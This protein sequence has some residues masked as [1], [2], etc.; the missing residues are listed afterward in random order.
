MSRKNIIELIK[1]RITPMDSEKDEI[2]I[3]RTFHRDDYKGLD[4]IITI[5]KNYPKLKKLWSSFEDLYGQFMIP[6]EGDRALIKKLMIDLE[7]DNGYFPKE[8]K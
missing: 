4:E 1:H 7:I 8:E 5:L 3:I 2:N 6:V